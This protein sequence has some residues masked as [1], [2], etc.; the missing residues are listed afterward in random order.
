[1]VAIDQIKYESNQYEAPLKELGASLDLT[2]KKLR[3][4]EIEGIME[5]EGFWNDADKAQSYMKELKNLKDTIQEY[6][7]LEAKYEDLYDYVKALIAMRKA[8]PAFHMGSADAVRTNLT[9]LPYKGTNVIAYHLNGAA[10][11]DDWSDIIVIL[12]SRSKAARVTVP[13]GNYTVVC[14]D[15]KISA[16]GITKVKGK[17]VNVPAQSAIIMYK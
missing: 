7:E 17:S 9:F 8:H 5:E 13:Q 12:N 11:G 4:E 14:Q 2:N 6:K 10:V 16:S 15:G 3:V 1:M